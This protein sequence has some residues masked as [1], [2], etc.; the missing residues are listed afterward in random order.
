M[1]RYSA[2][3]TLLTIM[4][5]VPLVSNA[6]VYLYSLST[7]YSGI[8]GLPSGSTVSW[9][10]EVPSVPA[11]GTTITN[12]LS[13]SLGPGFSSCG[14]CAHAQLPFPAP[15]PYTSFVITD[16]TGSCFGGLTGV[17]GFTYGDFELGTLAAGRGP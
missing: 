13:T 11:T 1:V 9:Q 15:S 12:F 8:S 5:F 4:L 3:A 10:F 14:W 2:I 17:K 6:S 7:D 16:F